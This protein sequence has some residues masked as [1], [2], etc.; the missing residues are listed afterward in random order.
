LLIARASLKASNV[1]G[2]IASLLLIRIINETTINQ[3]IL[4]DSRLEIDQ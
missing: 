4:K 1:F 3:D 2:I